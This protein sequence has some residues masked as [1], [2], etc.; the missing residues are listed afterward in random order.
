MK[1]LKHNFKNGLS[2]Q[3]RS[4]GYF[5]T[6]DQ[7]GNFSQEFGANGGAVSM[8]D[9]EFLAWVEKYES[10]NGIEINTSATS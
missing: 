7:E 9:A 6:S 4:N 5:Y 10:K 3:R 2:I 8:S 1:T